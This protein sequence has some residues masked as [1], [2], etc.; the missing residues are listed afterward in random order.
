MR[1]IPLTGMPDGA[2]ARSLSARRSIGFAL[3][4]DR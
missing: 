1:V 4:R 2:I 3:S